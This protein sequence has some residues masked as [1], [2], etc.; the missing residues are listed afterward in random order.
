M[1][2]KNLWL[3]PALRGI[4]ALLFA[5]I[6]FTHPAISVILIINIFGIFLF[7]FGLFMGVMSFIR[8]KSDVLWTNHIT[9]AVISMLIGLIIWLWPGLTGIVLM[10]IIAFWA[11]ISGIIQ[12]V[13]AIR[14][15][16]LMGN[17][18]VGTIMGALLFLV[19]LT[20]LVHPISGLSAVAIFIGII[21]AIYGVLSLI[22]SWQVAKAGQ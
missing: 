1:E 20:I 21:A 17:M 4:I 12:I 9:D 15:R 3:L 16:H 22:L 7:V 18:F 8:R 5:V 11:M 13:T 2:L 6:L 19:G 10:Y 14:L